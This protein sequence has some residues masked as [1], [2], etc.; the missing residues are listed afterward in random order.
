MT[1]RNQ[2]CKRCGWPR[3]HKSTCPLPPRAVRLRRVKVGTC[4]NCI[5]PNRELYATELD[6]VEYWICGPCN[7][8]A[9]KGDGKNYGGTYA[10]RT[11]RGG[12]PL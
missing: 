12:R 8:D 6:G 11:Q 1:K 3:H 2:L 7:Q 4:A 9:V 10:P 5:A